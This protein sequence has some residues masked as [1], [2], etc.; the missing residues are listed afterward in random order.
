MESNDWRANKGCLANDDTHISQGKTIAGE[1][2]Y[3]YSN[4]EICEQS[5]GCGYTGPAGMACCLLLAAF[6]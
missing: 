4:K 5:T 3:R 2:C 6:E 1:S